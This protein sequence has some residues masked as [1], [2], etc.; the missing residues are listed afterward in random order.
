LK[1][2]A[3]VVEQ[4]KSSTPEFLRWTLAVACNLKE[5]SQWKNPDR[6]ERHLR[7]VRVCETAIREGR[8]LDGICVAA[9]RC[10][11]DSADALGFR[12]ADVVESFGN[13]EAIAETCGQ[14]AANAIKELHPTANVGCFG[15]MPITNIYVH[16]VGETTVLGETNLQQLLDKILTD[17]LGL[18]SRIA[19][20]FAPTQPAWYGLW[21]PDS[22]SLQQRQVQLEVMDELL[23]S[24]TDTQ[25]NSA[26]K[27]FTTAL[28]ISVQHDFEIRI[29]LCPAGIRDNVNWTVP[30][31]CCRC[32]APW[33]PDLRKSMSS[34]QI[35]RYQGHPNKRHQGFVQGKR[36]YWKLSQFLGE[37]QAALFLEQYRQ[38]EGR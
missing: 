24:V 34:W 3:N 32:H 27:L 8:V 14:C 4:R 25:V 5:F 9:E 36:P 13:L 12:I 31:H 15:L 30:E 37:Q 29:E 7:A 28:R 22:P 17:N 35:C 21:I 38:R 1:G 16:P 23:L 33:K 2:F 19:K 26:W 10:D 18:S 11:D 20:C 6:V